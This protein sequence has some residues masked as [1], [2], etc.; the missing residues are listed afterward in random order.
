VDD[1][2]LLDA[3]ILQ[4]DAKHFKNLHLLQESRLSRRYQQDRKE[5]KALQAERKK[6]EEEKEEDANGFEFTTQQNTSNR[7][8]EPSR[9]CQKAVP[10]S[11][12]TQTSPIID[13][14]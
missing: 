4:E 6:Q 9:T 5:L 7:H 3:Y 11:V 8:A 10:T 2:D 14:M 12:Q 1:P 13:R